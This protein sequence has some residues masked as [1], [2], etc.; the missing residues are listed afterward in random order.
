MGRTEE[1]G[2]ETASGRQVEEKLLGK[3][4][5][6]LAEFPIT[7][8]AERRAVSMI[9]REVITRDERTGQ[10]VIRKVTITGSE[11]FGLPTGQDNLILLGLI[12]LTKRANNFNERKIWFTRSELFR[13]LG[14]PDSGQSHR[15]L[16][17]SLKRW[18]QLFVLYENAW[19]D[20]P[21]QSY[22]NKGFGII[23][24]FELN[25]PKQSRQLALFQS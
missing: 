2:R 5:M 11:A 18:G 24:D 7:L 14:W 1:L 9:T 16:A 10:K 8:L 23:D 22:S 25:D 3:D 19:W 6:N 15:R 20:K 13:V 17:L 4:E 21:K 12:Y